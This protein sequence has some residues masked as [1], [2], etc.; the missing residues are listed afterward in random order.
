MRKFKCG[1]CL[2]W[3]GGFHLCIGRPEFREGEQGGMPL[4]ASSE[5][6]PKPQTQEERWTKQWASTQQR[7]LKILELYME[8]EM[9]LSDVGDRMGLSKTTVRRIVMR[10]GGVIRPKG[11]QRKG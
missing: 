7:D 6:R 5:N 9:K 10:M 1:D 4:I 11:T 3:N 2:A 8:D